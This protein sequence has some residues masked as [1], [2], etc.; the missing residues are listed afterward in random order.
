MAGKG[1][2]GGSKPE[3]TAMA[4]KAAAKKMRAI[5]KVRKGV[6]RRRRKFGPIKLWDNLEL[7][8]GPLTTDDME[9]VDSRLVDEGFEDPLAEKNRHR[10]NILLLIHKA[11]DKDGSK[12][13][14]F[15][16]EHYLR[17]EADYLIMQTMIAFMY[18]SAISSELAKKG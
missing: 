2:K 18:E 1:G 8:F 17:T 13:F 4:A 9:A 14:Q 12:A 7:W 3:T 11:E 10:R 5:D 16:D 6:T 15:G